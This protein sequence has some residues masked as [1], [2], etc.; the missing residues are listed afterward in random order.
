MLVARPDATW[1]YIPKD[2]RHPELPVKYRTEF[3]F[4]LPTPEEAKWLADRAGEGILAYGLEVFR[5]LCMGW[6]KVWIQDETGHECEMQYEEEPRTQP[7]MGA[8]ARQN[9]PRE[10]L[11]ERFGPA[12]IIELAR[13]AADGKPTMM[14]AADRGN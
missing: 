14:T 3:V 2:D 5:A 12:Q 10:S 11:C 4:R 6:R 8:R 7:L 1:T 13:A 9:A